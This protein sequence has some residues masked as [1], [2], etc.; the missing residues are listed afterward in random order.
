MRAIYLQQIPGF[1][2]IAS[3]D[4]LA[5]FDRQRLEFAKR[6]VSKKHGISTLARS[7]LGG[8]VHVLG[9]ERNGTIKEYGKHR[10]QTRIA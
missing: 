3:L 7:P 1:A 5:F 9:V 10:G 8:T 6:V 4:D 2:P